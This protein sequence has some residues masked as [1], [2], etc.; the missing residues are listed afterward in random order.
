MLISILLKTPGGNS[1]DPYNLL[2]VQLSLL[3]FCALWT[4]T[5]LTALI[6][7]CHLLNSGKSS[8]FTQDPPLFGP[9]PRTFPQKATLAVVGF[10]SFIS[11]L[12]GITDLHYLVSTASHILSSFKLFTDKGWNPLAIPPSWLEAEICELTFYIGFL[13]SG[14]FFY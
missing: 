3:W 5:A 9:Q 10:N 6:S 1:E 14:Q 8:G 11:C 4:Q 2:S 7:P 12:S 13:L